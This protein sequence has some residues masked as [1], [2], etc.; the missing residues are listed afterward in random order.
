MK[1]ILGSVI[2]MSVC[3]LAFADIQDVSGGILFSYEDANASEIFLAGSLNEWNSSADKLTKDENGIWTIKKKLSEGSYTYKFVVDG[4]W[5]F[6]QTNPDFEEDGYGGS[7]SVVKVGADGKLLKTGTTPVS[8]GIKATFNPKIYFTG[9]YFTDNKFRKDDTDRFLLDKPEHDINLGFKIKFNNN[10]EGFT[11]MNINNNREGTEM[12]KSH[13]N[14]KRSFLKMN[15][16]VFNLIAFDN[17]PIVRFD[18][19]LNIVGNT[20]KYGYDFGF[21]YRGIHAE[22]QSFLHIVFNND[23]VIQLDAEAMYSDNAFGTDDIGAARF[24]LFSE[25]F[26]NHKFTLGRSYYKY[27]VNES[28]VLKTHYSFAADMMYS[29]GFNQPNWKDELRFTLYSEVYGFENTNET[30][31][32]EVWMKGAKAL[33]GSKFLFPA[34]LSL[35]GEFQLNQIDY[36]FADVSASKGT[37]IFGGNFDAGPFLW[38]VN[39]ET[40]QNDKPDSL[41]SSSDFYNFME[42]TDGNGRWYQTYNEVPFSK[43]SV[44]G[45]DTGFVWESDLVYSTTVFGRSLE[46]KLNSVFA[47]H[48]LGSMPKFIENTFVFEYELTKKWKLLT[49][50]R[51]PFYNDDF[52]EINTDFA[53][54]IDVFISNYSEISFNFSPNTRISVGY[55]VSPL[56]LDDVTDKFSNNGRDEFLNEAG[57]LE[58]YLE[59]FYGGFG[60][61]IREA[62]EKLKDEQRITIQGVIE[63]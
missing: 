30:D 39:F 4:N 16:D 53:E 1:K 56:I 18:D 59:T 55:G 46:T 31:E 15:T 20:G 14:Y 41:L 24:K 10:F 28:D 54:K 26:F 3:A 63:F 48:K 40:W 2:I 34:A 50:T 37:I 5:N 60:N 23:N 21:G 36:E 43:Y 32:K 47:H 52:L 22:K 45:Y 61:R 6:D 58:E 44:L 38:D 11:M 9:R 42:R 7:N 33:A 29:Y 49:D 13:L 8:N 27:T 19:P 17:M 62:E 25:N 51:I 35:Y 57:G 12:W